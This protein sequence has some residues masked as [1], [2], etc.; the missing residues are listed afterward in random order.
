[1]DPVAANPAAFLAWAEQN[2]R[3]KA[4]VKLREPLFIDHVLILRLEGRVGPEGEWE[5]LSEDT[6]HL[7][8]A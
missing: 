6:V 2:L 7:P 4:E 5:V 1:M 3:I 8:E